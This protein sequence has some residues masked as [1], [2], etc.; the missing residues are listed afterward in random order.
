MEMYVVLPVV[1]FLY[2]VYFSYHSIFVEK[3]IKNFSSDWQPETGHL[4]LRN[5]IVC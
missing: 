1:F 2:P 5:G 3:S 4:N